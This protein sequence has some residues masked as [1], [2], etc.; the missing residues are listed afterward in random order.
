MF[1]SRLIIAITVLCVFVI[2]Q[3]FAE[4]K[5]GTLDLF[6]KNDNGDRVAPYGASV[7]IYRDLET[8]PIKVINPLEVN[9][10]S[11]S[12]LQLGHRYKIEIYVNSIYAD[13]DFVDMQKAQEKLDMTIKNSG[14]MRLS[15][16]YKDGQTPLENVMVMIR[17]QDG[18]LWYSSQTDKAGQTG[19][20]WLYPIVNPSDYY[21]AEI[22]LGQGIKYTYTP[23]KLLPNVAQE[24]KVVTKWPVIVDKL[25][26]VEVYNSTKN[27]ID[28]QDGTFVAQLY[29]INKKKIAESEVT[30]KGLAYF[31]KLK[32]G[33]YA[34]YIKSK[35]STGNLKVMAGK[36]VTVSEDLD[37]IKVYLHNPEL[38]NDYLNCNCV[39]FR[40]DDVQDFFL[41]PAQ[42]GIMTVFHQKQVPLTI[43]V[44]GAVIGTDSKLVGTIK[45]DLVFGQ[46]EIAN[47]SWRHNIYT[48][49]TKAEQQNDLEQTN[50]KIQEVFGVT[51]VTFIPPQNLFNNDTVSVL[52]SLGFTHL[53]SGETGSIEEP[54]KFKKSTFYEF[55]TFATTAELNPDTGYWR[56][57]SNA[58]TMDQINSS[59]FNYGYAVVMLHPYEY[60]TY[61]NGGYTSTVNATK[62]Q[63][64]GLLIDKVNSEGYK[65][66]KISDIENFGAPQTATLPQNQ[67]QED[68]T[69]IPN[70][71]C[72]AFRLDNVQDFWLT[73]VQN[74]AIDTFVQ[75][76]VPL[77]VT[78]IGK[79]IGDDP[80]AVNFIKEKLAK[81]Q[82]K[83]ANRGW[84]YVDHASY[85]KENQK[86]SIKQTND[87]LNK[88]FGKTPVLFSPPYDTF[89]KD[90]I[91]SAKEL[92]LAYFSASTTKDS[93][94]FPD[95]SIKHIPSTM[96]LTNL[97]DDDPFYSGT[98]P[99]K[100]LAKIQTNIKQYGYAAISLQPSDLAVKTDEYKNEVNSEKLA[101]LKQVLAEIKSAQIKTI[102]LESI[103]DSLSDSTI[104]IPDWIKNNAKWWSEGKIGD[105]DFTKDLQYLIEQKVIKIPSTEKGAASQKIP[106]WI[107]NNAKWWSEGKIEN[108]DFVKGIQ[109]LIQNGMIAV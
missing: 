97:I 90:T 73:D 25:I 19:R 109:Y 105:S 66:L 43:G 81:S 16:F 7:K 76:K 8:T 28:K 21:Y 10:I 52:K 3:A 30:N 82:L 85:N 5:T 77:T 83:I 87:K 103:P 56:P 99:E 23:I 49:M 20:V 86:A 27:K 96:T 41:S 58:A 40:L 50:K 55:P 14:G 101:I 102:S 79:F 39:A 68:A 65:V 69:P 26:T 54:P 18:K 45:N 6:V 80:K 84:E 72:V 71:N 74:T 91:D 78:A 57:F 51:P 31:S 35:D 48:K 47:H 106:D 92:G 59:I 67:T 64:L 75:N 38:N 2:P 32:I 60:S 61:E 36:K 34:L 15:V 37:V 107:K 11:I 42:V 100:A 108:S 4:E 95:D 63:D 33:N 53:S 93:P 70:C 1:E 29:D 24:F 12:S 89:N 9:P 17:S 104:V 44:I 13:V 62:L 94:P 98:I 46:T 22:I 88:V